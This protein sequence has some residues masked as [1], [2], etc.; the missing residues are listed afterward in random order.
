MEQR[1]KSIT[2][3]KTKHPDP[4]KAGHALKAKRARLDWQNLEPCKHA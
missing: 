4:V 1:H 2:E 3:V